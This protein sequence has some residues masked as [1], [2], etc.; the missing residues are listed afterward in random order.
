MDKVEAQRLQVVATLART[1]K[2]LLADYINYREI[3]TRLVEMEEKYGRLASQTKG[4]ASQPNNA[5]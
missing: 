3:E 1:Y 2:D 5:S 4:D